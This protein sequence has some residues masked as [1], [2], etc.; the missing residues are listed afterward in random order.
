MT[1]PLGYFRR[2]VLELVGELPSK[3]LA[4]LL[5]ALTTL[6]KALAGCREPAGIPAESPACG[7][8]LV[9]W[10]LVE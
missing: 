6:P 7:Q 4:D 9:E 8:K 2:A 1:K 5:K 3:P 10:S